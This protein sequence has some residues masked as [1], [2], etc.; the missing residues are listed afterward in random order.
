MRSN[1]LF[2]CAKPTAPK[3]TDIDVFL[4]FPAQTETGNQHAQI[5]TYNSIQQQLAMR[6]VTGAGMFDNF[7]NFADGPKKIFAATDDHTVPIL[8]GGI[9][10]STT[11]ASR[12][13]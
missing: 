6:D 5:P 10:S 1:K 4:P 2:D 9:L 12:T 7:E 13:P 11:Q 8:A 3:R